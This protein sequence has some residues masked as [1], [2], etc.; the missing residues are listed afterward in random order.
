MVPSSSTGLIS[1]I[2]KAQK[3]GIPV[4][5]LDTRI[6]PEAVKEAGLKPAGDNNSYFQ[7]R[8]AEVGKEKRRVTLRNV[9]G[10]IPG[11]NPAKKIAAIDTA[12]PVASE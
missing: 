9:M 11:K 7:S 2:K 8:E 10:M 12:P 3:A 6:D 4:V 1:A 5:N